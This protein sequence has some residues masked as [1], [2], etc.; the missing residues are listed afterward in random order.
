MA[1][2]VDYIV[3]GGGSAGLATARR[4]AKYGQ[5]VV[6]IEPK[7]LGGTCVNVGCVPKK[8][9][10]NAACLKEDLEYCA[11]YGI[12][13]G[14][15]MFNW[16][17]LKQ[18]RDAEIARLNGIYQRNVERDRINFV[19]G[20]AK[21]VDAH[22]VEVEGQGQFTAPHITIAV[23][24][25]SLVPRGIEGIDLAINSDGFFELETQP[26][27]V[28]I[29]GSGYIATEIAG[30]FR[31]LGSEV[32]LVLGPWPFL[33]PFDQ[34]VSALLRT[35][36][37]ANGVIFMGPH[38]TKKI[39]RLPSGALHVNY[40]DGSEGEY[41]CVMHAIGR[42]AD[43]RALNLPAVGLQTNRFGYLEVDDFQNS[44]VPGIYVLG[45][46]TGKSMLTP[47]AVKA[48]RLL[49]DRL[50]GGHPEAKMDYTNVPTVMF[51]HPQLGMV[52]LPEYMAKKQFGD[53]Q[54]RC[55]KAQFNAM[56][57]SFT[58]HK[59]PTFVKMVCVGPEEKVVGLHF[60]GRGIEEMVQGFAVA[61]KVGATRADFNNTVGIHPTV[62]EEVVLLG[63]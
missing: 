9:M 4:A 41:D 22:T 27:R 35:T 38:E 63:P 40:T 57:Y 59:T 16:N 58:E 34:E 61:L 39:E 6:M 47:V 49:S 42:I 60:L 19:H 5:R 45:D 2:A 14:Q 37:E 15:G 54:V 1:A 21:F 43:V 10:W 32:T 50:F 29:I 62:G 23:G 26:A 7:R 46:A 8:L 12:T 55:Y 56:F 51:A 31:A 17:E 13:V 25:F 3:I 30:I 28:M 48:G 52:G 11:G 44:A 24:S 36:M 18:R 33:E 53:D 20:S